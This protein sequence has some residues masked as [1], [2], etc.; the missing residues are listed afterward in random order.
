MKDDQFTRDAPFMIIDF[1]ERFMLETY[2]QKLSDAQAIVVLPT[3]PVE[4][5]KSQ[6]ETVVELVSTEGGGVS[7]WPE[8]VQYL[9][10][11][12]AESFHING[13]IDNL[14]E[15]RRRASK[16]DCLFP[17]RLNKEITRCVNVHAPAE[18]ITPFIVA[19]HPTNRL[20]VARFRASSQNISYL[21]YIDYAQHEKDVVCTRMETQGSTRPQ[22]MAART[23]HLAIAQTNEFELDQD[24]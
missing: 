3:F 17:A 5:A 23:Q 14:Q 8:A 12:Y 1:L 7:S 19:F 9:W 24:K 15:M 13:T 22:H 2:F 10:R 18:K 11:S 20:I 6:Y 21:D 16:K 4:F